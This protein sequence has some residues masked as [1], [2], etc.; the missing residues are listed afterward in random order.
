MQLTYVSTLEPSMNRFKIEQ[1]IDVAAVFNQ[2]V[3][4]TGVIAFDR[5]RVCQI[6]EGEQEPVESLFASIERDPRH[7]SVTELSRREIVEKHFADWGMIERSM[8]D[9][10]KTLAID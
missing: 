2:S 9:L 1:L 8:S 7:S 4:I 5:A 3:G 6:L 10:E